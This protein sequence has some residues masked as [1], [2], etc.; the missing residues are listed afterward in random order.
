MD[1]PPITVVIS[2]RNR[3]ESIIQTIQTVLKNDY[4]HFELRVV[5]QSEDNFTESSLQPFLTDPR[6]LHKKTATKGVSQGRNLG[7][8]DAKSELIAIIDDDCEAPTNWLRELAAA[9][10][11][12][13]RI[14]IVFGNVFPG[15]HDPTAGFIPVYVRN[16]PFLAKSIRDKHRVEGISACMGLRRSVWE[17]IRGFDEMLG[18]GAHFQSAGEVDITIRV[19]LAGYFVYETPEITVLHHGFRNWEQGKWLMYRYWYGTGA[20]LAKHLICGHWPIVP[21]LARLAWRWAFGVSQ[22]AAGFGKNSHKWFRLAT[23]IRGFVTGAITPIDKR[24]CHYV[25]K[26]SQL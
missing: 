3:S 10:A 17:M 4:P 2:T 18:A 13:S 26:D 9:F 22:V 16:E 7:I 24:I 21:L 11:V 14:G 8:H 15:P 6:I 5:D 20:T 12:D 25:K 19:L 1:T 23:F